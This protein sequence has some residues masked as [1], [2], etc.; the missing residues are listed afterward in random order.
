MHVLR[1]KDDDGGVNKTVK[2]TAHMYL[3]K[4]GS[5]VAGRSVKL[6]DMITM[7]VQLGEEYL[8]ELVICRVV[9]CNYE[10]I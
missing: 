4:D 5:D 3:Y 2:P 1:D 6:T 7:T 9:A 8:G 10:N